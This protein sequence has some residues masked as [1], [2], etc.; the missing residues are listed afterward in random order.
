MASACVTAIC[1]MRTH[2][3]SNCLFRALADQL[4]DGHTNH[5][6]L[7]RDVVAYMRE[8][9]DQFAPFLEEDITFNEYRKE[10]LE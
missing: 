2:S 4:R 6:I 1:Y 9:S 5:R 10:H 7:R 3:H 8:N